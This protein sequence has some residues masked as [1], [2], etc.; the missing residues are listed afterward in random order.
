MMTS[1]ESVCQLKSSLSPVQI[2]ILV[3]SERVLQF[4]SDI[5]HREVCVYVPGRKKGYGACRTTASF[6]AASAACRY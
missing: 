6:F 5:S 3:N 4:V 1:L 2:Q